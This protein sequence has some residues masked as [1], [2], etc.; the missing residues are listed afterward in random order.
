MGHRA[1]QTVRPVL[2]AEGD[3]LAR[4]ELKRAMRS[5]VHERVSTETVTC[6]K[7]GGH[8]VVRRSCIGTMHNLEV[9]VAETC[10][11]LRNQHDIPELETRQSEVALVVGKTVA[12][13]STI[14]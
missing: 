14:D 12:R 6:P 2:A 9:V 11:G 10:R 3:L 8:V 5:E 1:D 4:C 7:I 13:E